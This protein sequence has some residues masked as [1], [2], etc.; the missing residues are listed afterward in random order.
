[1][2]VGVIVTNGPKWGPYP[3]SLINRFLGTRGKME[4]C[5]EPEQQPPHFD[6]VIDFD[7]GEIYATWGG[8]IPMSAYEAKQ[9]DA[10]FG[11]WF[12]S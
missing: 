12:S 8:Q 5:H 1:M 4:I 9:F 2:K 10:D 11:L 6:F 3:P 7:L